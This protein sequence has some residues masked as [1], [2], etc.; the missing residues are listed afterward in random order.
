LGHI[1]SLIFCIGNVLR[2]EKFS[3]C[4]KWPHWMKLEASLLMSQNAVADICV[5][6]EHS[7]HPYSLLPHHWFWAF[8]NNWSH[9]FC[10]SHISRQP[11]FVDPDNIRRRVWMMLLCLDFNGFSAPIVLQFHSVYALS[12]VLLHIFL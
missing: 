9:D 6:A 12:Q 11:W 10:T 3:C 7:T 4:W 5:L 2:W 1:H 8:I